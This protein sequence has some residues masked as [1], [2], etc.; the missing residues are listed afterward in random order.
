M[1]SPSAT[2]CGVIGAP[3][4]AGFVAA[5]LEVSFALAGAVAAAMEV[6]CVFAAVLGCALAAV[7][8]DDLAALVVSCRF[9]V[10]TDSAAVA[11]VRALSAAPAA[12]MEV[13]AGTDEVDWP[14]AGALDMDVVS[15]LAAP[16]PPQAASTSSM[17]ARV[18]PGIV[19]PKSRVAAPDTS[20]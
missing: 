5:A 1:L 2:C 9:V 4:G 11:V 19:P 13:S 12:V 3:P 14:A 20:R 16:P 8:T 17:P 7:L 15:D 6:S 18:V 10:P